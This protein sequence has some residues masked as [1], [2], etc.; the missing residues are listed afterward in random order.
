MTWLGLLL[1][2]LGVGSVSS[3]SRALREAVL[4]RYRELMGLGAAP[5]RASYGM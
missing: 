4:L 3:S 2:V 5:G 1:I